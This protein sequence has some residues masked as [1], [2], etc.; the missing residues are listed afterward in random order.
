MTRADIV[1]ASTAAPHPIVRR[2]MLAPVMSKRR[3]KPLFLID[4]ALPRDID[5]DVND[6]RQRVSAQHRRPCRRSWS[7]RRRARAGEA[8]AA[9]QIVVE[10]TAAFLHWLRSRTPCR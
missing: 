10:E 5:P 9:E 2:D 8:G 4:I 6:T 7:S 3:G 1:I